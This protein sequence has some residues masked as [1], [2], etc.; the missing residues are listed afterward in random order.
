M[1]LHNLLQLS[2]PHIIFGSIYPKEQ[3]QI[4]T[5]DITIFFFVQQIEIKWF[6]IITVRAFKEGAMRKHLWVFIFMNMDGFLCPLFTLSSYKK[7]SCWQYSI[8]LC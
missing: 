3:A 6:Y 2:N 8:Y 5:I 7:H 1:H 4:M